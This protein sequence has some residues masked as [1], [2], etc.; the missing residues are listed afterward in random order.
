MQAARRGLVKQILMLYDSR[1]PAKNSIKQFAPNSYYHL[2]N[3]GVEKRSIF[4]DEQ[5]YT[6]FTSYLKTYLLPKNTKRL[7]EIIGD[8]LSSSKDK[9]QAIKLLRMNNFAGEL[10]LLS[11]CLIP[12]HFHFLVRQKEINTIDCFMNSLFTR[13]SMYFNR[14]YH[15]VGTLFQGVYKAVLVNTDEQLLHLSR[16]IHRNPAS[17]G[18]AL[19]GYPHSSYPEYL[20]KRHTNWINTEIILAFFSKSG[21][22]SYKSFVEDNSLEDISIEQIMTLTLDAEDN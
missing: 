9:D 2:Y 15:R 19:Q 1:M 14:K 20:V 8:P 22:N 16:Y 7:Q 13:Y 17:Q 11:Y 21:L 3:R 5:D 18:E 6:V 4:I 12:N 10:T